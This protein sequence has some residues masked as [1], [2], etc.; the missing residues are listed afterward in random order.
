MTRR[1]PEGRPRNGSAAKERG[2]QLAGPTVQ[3]SCSLAELRIGGERFIGGK[4]RRGVT[5]EQSA[6]SM[7][8]QE[9]TQGWIRG[10]ESLAT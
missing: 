1:G 9:V 4:P 8:T 3:Y 6:E 2:E 10:A 5:D 7:T